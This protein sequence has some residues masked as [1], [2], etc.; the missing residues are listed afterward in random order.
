MKETDV[1][2]NGDGGVMWGV[3][4]TILKKTAVA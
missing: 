2:E 1:K 4:D 3:T